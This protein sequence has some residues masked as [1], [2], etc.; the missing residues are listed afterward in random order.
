M[1]RYMIAPLD[2]TIEELNIYQ[3]IY[4]K[5]DFNSWVS[6]YTL[7]QLS[8]DSHQSLNISKKVA[9]RIVN[10]LIELNYLEIVRVGVK[11]KATLYRINREFVWNESGTNWERIGNESG[12]NVEPVSMLTGSQWNESVT[13]LVRI[14]N[15]SVT[16]IKDKDKEKEK[17]ES[18]SRFTPPTL[19]EVV[20]YC[21]E[22]NSDVDPFKFFEYF[23]TGNWKDSKGNKVK[24][25]KQ[26]LITWEKHTTKKTDKNSEQDK[27]KERKKLEIVEVKV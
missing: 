19:E 18:N 14:G 27:P 25:W 8:T 12:M 22:R 15:E 23:N 9:S 7:D 5:A 4:K 24:N 11:G 3:L 1:A 2:L 16:P 21:K 26:K 10:K 6:D 20:D 13:N 17:K